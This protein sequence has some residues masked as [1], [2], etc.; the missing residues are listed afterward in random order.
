MKYSGSYASLLRGV[1]QQP[2]ELRQPGQHTEQINMIPDPVRG[3]TR[4]QGAAYEASFSPYPDAD[5]SLWSSAVLFAQAGGYRKVLHTTEGKDYVI[6]IRN[7]AN[8]GT[9]AGNMPAIVCYN[10]T[11]K[12][13]CSIN[14][15]T[16][17]GAPNVVTSL[18]ASGCAAIVSIGAYIAYAINGLPCVAT[19]VPA[20]ANQQ[21]VIWIR[22]GAYNR[23]YKVTGGFGGAQ[24]ITPDPAAP[25]AAAAIAP[26]AI[27]TALGTALTAA[28]ALGVAVDGSHIRFNTSVEFQVNDG[29]DGSL[30]RGVYSKIDDATELPLYGVNGML[31]EVAVP[32]A[33][34]YYVKAINKG[35]SFFGETVWTESTKVVQASTLINFG[36]MKVVGN[37]LSVGMTTAAN[38]TGFSSIPGPHPQILASAVGDA[39]TNPAPRWMNSQITYM[40]MFQDRLL[41]GAKAAMA[42]S[43]AGD[44]Y[45]FF[46]S[47]VLT[48]PAKDAFEMV[49]QGSEDDVLRHGV[50]YNKNL[51]IFGDKRQYVIPGAVALTPTSANMSVL[52]SYPDATKCPPVAAGGLIYYARSS[53]GFVG[54]HQIQP[55]TFVDSTES[56]PA[57]AQVGSYIPAD[58]VELE[59][60]PG[61]PSILIARSRIAPRSLYVFHYLDAQDGR[62]QEAW[63]TWNFAPAFGALLGVVSTARGLVV[64]SVRNSASGNYL[65]SDLLPTKPIANGGFYLDSHRS[66]V[67]GL[68]ESTPETPGAYSLAFDSTTPRYLMGGPLSTSS[69]WQT[70]YPTE[71]PSM[72]HGFAFTSSFTPTNPYPKDSKGV[73]ITTGRSVVTALK[74][75]TV[76]SAGMVWTLASANGSVVHTDN[77]RVVSGLGDLVGTIPVGDRIISAPVGREVREYTL[78][79][80]ALDWRPLTVTSIS[81]VGQSF[82]RTP[83]A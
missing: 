28:G 20:P 26:A 44:Y 2:P 55:G 50:A 51:V 70:T 5:Y 45:N 41:I 66:I 69:Y 27:A 36:V 43:A 82:N 56:Y 32:G 65:F 40:G 72:R 35:G 10:L 17:A 25:G 33:P 39:T 46:R 13:F 78:T 11:D 42:V 64:I 48:V 67:T 75:S 18:R 68:P 71:Y 16:P 38:P 80:A 7:E 62:K 77:G 30:M 1:S 58:A 76:D 60:V 74:V 73:S 79:L 6:L 3:L 23:T 4:R 21:G 81:Y 37:I 29:G 22:G 15:N 8:A 54:I 49:A 14:I 83:S 63:H 19:S 12:V 57:S 9:G 47:T 31:V 59:H 53:Q 52:C 61:T 34:S 24:T